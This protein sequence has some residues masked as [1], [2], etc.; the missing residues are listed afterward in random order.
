MGETTYHVTL[1]IA[2]Q[3]DRE[4]ISVRADSQGAF[5]FLNQ[6]S[7]VDDTCNQTLTVRIDIFHNES[8]DSVSSSN[9]I[10]YDL[11]NISV[12]EK[13]IFE[14]LLSRSGSGYC[15]TTGKSSSSILWELSSALT[16]NCVNHG[17]SQSIK[18]SLQAKETTKRRICNNV[19]GEFQRLSHSISFKKGADRGSK[20]KENEKKDEN[21]KKKK[22]A[23]LDG[24]SDAEMTELHDVGSFA[25]GL[26][27]LYTRQNGWIQEIS[28][29][30]VDGN[31]DVFMDTVKQVE[32]EWRNTSKK[33]KLKGK[34]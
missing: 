14:M 21:G 32:T 29:G 10:E 9:A 13:T 8:S 24:L 19:H 18:D 11:S 16:D 31:S 34:S 22:Y 26:Q 12:Q 1:P 15:I 7:M 20:R 27:N 33:I 5:Q 6:H 17:R 23:V 3:E 28:S 4:D 2:S 25:Y 30:Y